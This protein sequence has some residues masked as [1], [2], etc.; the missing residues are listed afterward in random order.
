[1]YSFTRLDDILVSLLTGENWLI[2]GQGI[3]LILNHSDIQRKAIRACQ[4]LTKGH[5]EDGQSFFQK[6]EIEP[7]WIGDHST[8]G[9]H[10]TYEQHEL[11][12]RLEPDLVPN[13]GDWYPES[14]K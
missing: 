14:E 10:L 2:T 12:R 13:L 3:S 4:V 5:D 9:Y 6:L 11:L 1:V 7:P 8:G